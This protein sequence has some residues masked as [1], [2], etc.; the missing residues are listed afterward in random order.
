MGTQFQQALNGQG[1]TDYHIDL[2]D[3]EKHLIVA[4]FGRKSD[5]PGWTSFDVNVLI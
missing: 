1:R 4:S 3:E 5:P 2:Y